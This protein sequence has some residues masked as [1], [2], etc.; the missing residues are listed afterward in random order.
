LLHGIPPYP[1]SHNR[2]IILDE[3][4]A[5]L[6]ELAR[7]RSARIYR[8]LAN[9]GSERCEESVKTKVGFVEPMLS[10]PVAKLPDG[11]V[12]SYELK[13]DGYRA[14]GLKTEARIQLLS[15]NGKNFTKRFTLIAQALE[16]LPDET[17]I[18][19]EI[20][21]F[22][23]AGGPSFNVLQNHRNRETEIQFYVFDLLILRG[24]DL[25]KQSLEKRRELLRTKVMPRLPDTIRYSETLQASPADLIEAVREQGFEGIVAKR[26]DSLYEPGKRSGAW[27]KMR[28]L[29]SREF[30]IGGYT[31]GGR[32]F[33]G[34][35]IGYY[36]GRELV[37]V[38]KVH[39]GFTPAVRDAVSKRFRGLE[40]NRCPFTNLPE[41]YGGQW[42]EGLTVEQMKKCR[43]LKPRLIVTIEYLEWTAANHLRHAMFAGLTEN[44]G[45]LRTK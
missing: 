13:F 39:A 20:V 26:R 45:I 18:D 3:V 23:S 30:V 38:A 8:Y 25:T 5:A 24:K 41:A 2:A 11:P 29:Q 17:V 34:I 33:D 44:P 16:K 10:L 40:S 19:G 22:D 12:W 4:G 37:Y 27:Q 36:E 1:C 42:G 7:A 43:W 9:S 31:P 21:A 35:L 28:V 6:D 15:R 32:N 14:L